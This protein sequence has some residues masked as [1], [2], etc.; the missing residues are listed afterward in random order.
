MA[1]SASNARVA[2]QGGTVAASHDKTKVPME[3]AM[4]NKMRPIMHS[5]AGVADTWERFGNALDPTPPFPK[6]L[7]R[8]R[9]ATLIVPLLASSIFLTNYMV[10]KGL[11]F[12]IGF[13]F[14]GDPVIS[15][16]LEWL[17]A[18]YPNWQKLLELRNTVL[19]GIP[20]NAQLTITLLRI[21]EANK[22]P[23]P[24]P[25][26]SQQPPPDEP[27]EITDEH[28]RAAGSDWPLNATDEELKEA[29][30]HD[31]NTAHETAGADVD[32]AKSK[33]HG[34][35]GARLMSMIKGGVKGTVETALGA[36]R[37]KAKAG[38]EHAKQRVGVIHT[39]RENSLTARLTSSAA[40]TAR[41]GMCTLA[42]APLSRACL[43]RLT[44]PSARSGRWTGTTKSCTRSGLLL[45]RTSR[46]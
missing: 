32:A 31:P 30:E 34:K 23:L 26:T 36:D 25:P 22:A 6:E 38:S 46:N 14:F 18:H 41:E 40:T 12:G 3:T 5:L 19:K 28:L 27:V 44:N 33:S 9:L 13:G 7:Y 24:P 29:M 42:R 10:I 17:N 21:G 8:L 1:V 35:K 15:R 37:L 2:A 39:S 43:S 4:W 16:G 11:T 45:L 20:T